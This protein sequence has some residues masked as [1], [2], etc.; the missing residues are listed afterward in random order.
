MKRIILGIAIGLLAAS[1]GSVGQSSSDKVPS[2]EYNGPLLINIGEPCKLSS[3]IP[4]HIRILQSDMNLVLSCVA[5]D[6]KPPQLTI[7]QYKTETRDNYPIGGM[8]PPPPHYEQVQVPIG[9]APHWVCE[10]GYEPD[11]LDVSW[12]DGVFTPKPAR[13]RAAAK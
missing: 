8:E 13:C 10:K 4:G 1:A 2:L 3:G 11:G 5:D 6:G 9:P 7:Q 12:P